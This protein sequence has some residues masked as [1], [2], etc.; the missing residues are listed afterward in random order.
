VRETTEVQEIRVISKD[1]LLGQCADLY[2]KE[3]RLVQICAVNSGNGVE[4]SYSFGLEYNMITLRCNVAEGD[5]VPSVTPVW[6]GAFCYENEIKDLFGVKIENISVDF[7]G[8]FY[9]VAKKHP[10]AAAG[11]T[12]SGEK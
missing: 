3:Y 6:R 10:F 2:A 4:M 9:K 1:L 11:R 5:T 8:N 12:G 7:L